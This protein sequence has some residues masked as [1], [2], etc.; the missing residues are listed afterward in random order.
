MRNYWDEGARKNAAW[1]VDTTV[2][3]DEPDMAGFLEAG[4]QI[5]TTL[6]DEAPISPTE[7]GTALEIGSGLGRIC[8]ALSGRYEHVI[9]VDVSPEMVRRATELVT[10]PNVAFRVGDGTGLSGID[11]ASIDLIVSF[12][13]FQHIPKASIVHEYLTEAGRVLRPGGMVAFQWNNQTGAGRWAVRRA[14]L[15]ALQQTRIR[16]EA[17]DRHSPA[18]LGTCI[19]RRSIE[20]SLERG[21]LVLEATTG[22]GTLFAVAWARSPG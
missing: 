8:R 19:S 6:V 4:E 13:V 1:Y 2:A 12:T 10:E 21:G 16:P 15:S 20:R 17:H 22:L 7:R 3:Y 9:G 11:D 5:V 14:A 18:F